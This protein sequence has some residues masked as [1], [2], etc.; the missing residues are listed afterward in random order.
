[1]SLRHRKQR[2]Q[3]IDILENAIALF[4]ER[5]VDAVRAADIA[6]RCEISE[7]TFFNYFG[8]KDA[9][10]REWASDVLDQELARVARRMGE[11]GNLRRAMRVAVGDVAQ[12]IASEPALHAAAW[13]RFGAA[14][15]DPVTSGARGRS[16]RPDPALEMVVQAQQQGEC[17]VDV[18]AEHL[19]G[20]LRAVLVA[21]LASW[22]AAPEPEPRQPVEDRLAEACDLLLD[23]FRKR[24]ERVRQARAS[25]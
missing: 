12:R 2:Q 19:A 11:G 13:M 23:G 21:T 14:H 25:P 17:R 3:R 7:A 15:P 22:L 20:L 24:N 8:G 18:P 10:L 5:G 1:M 4:R 6:A 16:D 9:L